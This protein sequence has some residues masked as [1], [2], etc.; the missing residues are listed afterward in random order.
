MQ[1][2]QFVRG[3]MPHVRLDEFEPFAVIAAM[4]IYRLFLPIRDP[5]NIF[6]EEPALT[7]DWLPQC[8]LPAQLQ[9]QPL[10]FLE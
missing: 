7:V 4:R 5:M 9:S 6:Q 10:T 8:L 2:T 3:L 1:A